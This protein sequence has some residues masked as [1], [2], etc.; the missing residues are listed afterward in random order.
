MIP[1]NK[2]YID[3]KHFKN[4]LKPSQLYV[5]PIGGCGMFGMNMTCYILDGKMII[6][7]AGSLFPDAWMTGISVII[8]DPNF[9]LFQ[10]FELLAYFITHAHEDHI[11]A[12]PYLMKSNPKPIYTTPWTT[13]V[14]KRKFMEAMV[15]PPVIS[16]EA[17]GMVEVGPFTVKF[18]PIGHSIPDASCFL[19]KAGQYKVFHSGDFKFDTEN[20]MIP[21][22]LLE[23]KDANIDLFLCDSTNAEKDG[24]CPQENTVCDPLRSVIAEAKGNVYLASFSSNLMRFKWVADICKELGKTLYVSGT[25]MRANFDLAL[26]LGIVQQGSYRDEADAE[27]VLKNSVVLMSGCQGEYRSAL[28]RLA[29]NE[30]RYFHLQEHDVVVFSSRSIPGNEKN[31]ADIIDK[32]RLQDARIITA[33]ENPGIHVSGHAFGGEVSQLLEFAKPKTFI[34]VHGTHSQQLANCVRN[35]SQNSL[36]VKNGYVIQ[37][38]ES[39]TEVIGTLKIDTVYVDEEYS[40]LLNRAEFLERLRLTKK[41][42]AICNGVVSIRQKKWI[43]GPS[44]RVTGLVKDDEWVADLTQELRNF[45]SNS[46]ILRSDNSAEFISNA[47]RSYWVNALMERF[48]SK[49]VTHSDIWVLD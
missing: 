49:P 26:N 28:A 43:R 22:S 10:E 21:E 34:P 14:L 24:T 16:V 29:N 32:L 37:H 42:V 12:L 2:T 3:P 47:L 7:D 36:I 11:G 27:S 39:G 6:A 25:S 33:K 1:I 20:E 15:D 48:G 13:E 8:P 46:D 40:L 4:S 5:I 30:H 41:G 17:N 35:P 18:L 44:L 9:W 45:A 19:I 31:I 38:S 23:L